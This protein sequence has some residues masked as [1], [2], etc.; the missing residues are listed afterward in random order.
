[1]SS[2]QWPE[3]ASTGLSSFLLA[4]YFFSDGSL[5]TSLVSASGSSSEVDSFVFFLPSVS[6][7]SVDLDFLVFFFVVSFSSSS[8]FSFLD[9][10]FLESSSSDS[11]APSFSEFLV[12]FVL[13]SESLPA[14]SSESFSSDL[15]AGSS[16]SL[17]S[18]LA[19]SFD[20][21]FFYTDTD[22]SKWRELLC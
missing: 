22:L 18:D 13:F 21:D 10:S 17:L 7:S 9:V 6:S 16:E 12:F 2:A 20:S 1:M 3:S 11:A 19:L 15:V 14:G 4:D 5:E 8:A